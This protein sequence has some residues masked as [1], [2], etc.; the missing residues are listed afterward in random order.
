MEHEGRLR[1]EAE[2]RNGPSF[3]TPSPL[4]RPALHSLAFAAALV[5]GSASASLAQQSSAG[6]S[7]AASPTA[8]T[9][10]APAVGQSAPDFTL[11]WADASG[12]RAT[13]FTLSA[14]RGKVVVLAFYPKDR[15]GGCTAELTKFRDE[16]TSLFGPNAGK[17]VVVVPISADGLA[18]HESWAKDSKYPFAL[19]ADT[20]LTA[21]A[22]YGSRMEQAPLAQRTVFV[23]GRDGRV[24]YR[25]L[26][27]N[28]LSQAAY[29]ELKAA[30]A[31]A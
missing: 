16:F 9:A 12:A 21:A 22:A 5:A 4:M 14:L 3:P 26:K 24:T 23:I 6:P 15:T 27:F 2:R 17:D 25:N 20:A 29:D 8:A 19:V 11:P 18:S 13:P 31:A 28:A 1:V 30:V 7:A 10:A